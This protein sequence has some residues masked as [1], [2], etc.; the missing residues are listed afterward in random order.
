[1]LS[2]FPQIIC[3]RSIFYILPIILILSLFSF[4]VEAGVD[5]QWRGPDRDGKY[6]DK[7]LLKKWPSQGPDLIWSASELGEGFSSPAVTSESVYITGMIDGT[8]FLF[9]FDL[10]GKML[11]RASYG[12]EWDDGHD[13]A[14]STP[15]VVEDK[16]YLL[17]CLGR[18]VCLSTSDGKIIWEI[19][20]IKS[21]NARN[22]EWGMTESLVVDGDRLFCTPGGS[23]SMLVILDRLS[24]KT[25]KVV[26]GNGEKSAYASPSLIT[27]NDK[28]IIM[29]MTGESVVGVDAETGEYLWRQKHKTRYDINPNT[30]IYHQGYIYA[31][32]GY[33]TGGQVLKLTP[34]GKEVEQIWS[35]ETLD[36]QKG[37]TILLDG[38]IYGSGHDNKGWHCIN[39]KTGEVQYTAKELGNI[40][41]IIFADGL[42]YCYSERGD[43]GLVRPNP[44]KFDVI[45]SFEITEGSGPHWAHPVIMDGKLFVRHGDALM[46]YDIKSKK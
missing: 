37:A 26:K 17:S 8:G 30:P 36:C 12:P 38:Y 9:R 11:W 5:A 20:L 3:F 18:V 1:M 7:N 45:S 34:D 16:I 28:R 40:G 44:E 23:N 6:L 29:T 14:R 4:G 39:W 35:D 41:N 46:V 21:F 24:G 19:D 31:V 10:N 13:G 32:S 27:H 22:L 25:I 2:Q 33:G 15:T 42:L 43:V